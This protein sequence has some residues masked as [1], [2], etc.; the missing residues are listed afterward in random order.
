MNKN[1]YE[2]DV[3]RLQSGLNR[4]GLPIAVNRTPTFDSPVPCYL[5]RNPDGTIRWL[6]PVDADGPEFLRFY[7]QGSLRAKAFVWLVRLLF[8]CGLSQVVAH[9]RMTFYTTS[10]A[11]K[12]LLQRTRLN[13]WA[14]FTG[15]AGPNRKLVIWYLD[16]VT[17]NGNFLKIALSIP[18][19]NNLRR[20]AMA[21]RE[22]QEMPFQHLDSPRLIASSRGML[23][24]EDMATSD[25]RPLNRLADLPQ[26]AVQELMTRNW[27]TKPLQETS[28][29]TQSLDS[30]VK[31]RVT[32]DKRIP[33][34]LLD[35]LEEL[36]RR[37]DE[38][39][40][41]AVAAAHGDFTPWNILMRNNRLCVIDWELYRTELPGLYDLFHF[42]Y[43]S[44]TMLG[45]QGFNL[46][47]RE[48]DAT[49]QQY[50]W[51]T[52]CET[53]RVDLCVA[54]QLYLIHT[55]TYYLSVYSRQPSW[56][57]QVNWLLET[58]SNALTYWLSQTMMS[59]RTLLLHDLAFWLHKQPHAALKFLPTYLDE[60]PDSSDLDLCMP[61][62]VAQQLAGYV[63]QHP[64]VGQVMVED[65]TFMKQLHIYCKDGTLLHLDLIWAFKRKQLEFM[66]ANAVWER[67]SLASHGL[68]V[69]TL[70]SN[71]TYVRLFYGLNNAPVPA[72]YQ[73]LFTLPEAAS[74]SAADVAAIRAMPQNRGGRGMKNTVAYGWDTLRSFW[75]RRGMI[76]TFSGV[77]GAG[78]STVIEQ[79][80]HAIEKRLRQ[81][82]VVLRHRPSLL[83]ILS[84]W[85][86]GR[87]E[88]EQRSASRLPRQG[89]NTSRASSLLRFAYY[90]LDYLLGQFYVQMKYV[91]R[92]YIVLYDR[93][94]FDFI[95][96]SRRSNVQLPSGLAAG[97][98]RFLLKPELN[99]FL[100][101]PAEDI[102]RRKQ[103][104]DP[105]TI[106][107]LTR[108]YIGLFDQLQKKYPSSDYIPVLNLDLPTTLTQIFDRIQR[109]SMGTLPR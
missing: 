74:L 47:R 77:D 85:Q 37:L 84:A 41:I 23:I 8:R 17:S 52:F 96:D 94:Y 49:L 59:N 27:H 48:I 99:V 93:Y 87:Q 28:F 82:V 50:D 78:K 19:V 73:P 14:V 34:S 6:W 7:H 62:P 105:V 2:A 64:A 56:H 58:W 100:Y 88:A 61:Q 5:Y 35:K 68:N 108:Q 89:T 25:V 26:P 29:W 38:R 55:I 13:S 15:T 66:P 79:T 20:E 83:P 53:R 45:N 4:I 103:E 98:Y 65:R 70:E 72:R 97:L 69:P 1:V 76:V 18:A 42:Q 21:L 54:E 9:D 11:T 12:Q 75:F 40:P 57:R 104:L 63:R 31:L 46:I 22:A 81:R 10:A 107:E 92:G 80:K 43:Q 71:Q 44:M 106:T 60:L 102:L 24:Q 33:V 95:N 86:Y 91:W 30:L 16:T 109:C 90:F 51:A 3:R 67:A 36:I 39:K 32:S 101:A